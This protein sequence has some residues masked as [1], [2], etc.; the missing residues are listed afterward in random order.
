MP[1]YIIEREIPGAGELDWAALQGISK[2]S[3]AVLDELGPKIQWVRSCV[4][5]DK[6]YCEYISPNEDMI[7]EHAARGEFPANSIVEVTQVIDPTT[8]E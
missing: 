7:R 4:T 1:R 3:N 2:K 6:V 8:G 5:G